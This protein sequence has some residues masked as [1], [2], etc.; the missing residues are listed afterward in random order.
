M[1]HRSYNRGS[2][3]TWSSYIFND[4]RRV[5][6]LARNQPCGMYYLVSCKNKEVQNSLNS[7]LAP[8]RSEGFLNSKKP[9]LMV[10]L[11]LIL[12]LVAGLEPARCLHRGILRQTRFEIHKNKNFLKNAKTGQFRTKSISKCPEI[13]ILTKM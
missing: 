4:K 2:G 9:K 10:Q 8:Q 11:R 1:G 5:T 7:A 6:V 13:E 3:S 12:V